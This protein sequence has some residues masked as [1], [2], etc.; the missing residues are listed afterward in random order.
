MFGCGDDLPAWR[1]DTD[2]RFHLLELF[3]GASTPRASDAAVLEATLFESVV[4]ESPSVDPHSCCITKSSVT[5]P[6]REWP[7]SESPGCQ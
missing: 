6:Q 7:A 2:L 5:N 3:H 4:D 1:Y